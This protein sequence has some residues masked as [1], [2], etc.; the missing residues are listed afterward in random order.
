MIKLFIPV[1][2]G[3]TKTKVR[4]FW[5]SSFPAKKTYYDYLKA[6][7]TSYIEPKQL[8]KLKQKYNQEAIAFIDC[9]VLKIYYSKD[10]IEILN[11]KITK[12][13]TKKELKQNI[14]ELLKLYGGV[15]VYIQGNNKY[16]LEVFYNA[17]VKQ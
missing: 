8:G 2:K 3:K 16:L 9:N 13:V 6:I 7:N 14:K 4:G 17:E 12:I 1:T 11:N 5:R 10:K 15:T